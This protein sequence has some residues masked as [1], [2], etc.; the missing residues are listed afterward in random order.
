[1]QPTT[2]SNHG[3]MR[4]V[5]RIS[6]P[7]ILATSGHAL[8]LFADRVMLSQY[9]PEALAAAMPAGLT[10]FCLMAFFI[11]T[12][13]YAGTFVSQYTGAGQPHKTG[14]AIWQ[15]IWISLVGGICVGITAQY[16]EQITSWMQHG[17]AVQAY[18]IPYYD[19]LVRLSFSA[20]LLAALNAFWSGRGHTSVVMGIELFTAVLN[21]L[22]NHVLIFGRY[23]F[24]ELG[25]TGAGLA[26]G[27]S[28]MGGCLIA[29]ILFLSPENRKLFG[30]W[31][32]RL[33]QPN[34][35]TRF[36]RYG[37]PNGT[38][39]SL[40][41]IAF[42]LFVIFL[43][44]FGTAELEAAN[45]AFGLN[46]LAF[47]PLVGLG[48]AVSIL[49]GQCIGAGQI[50]LA[51][52]YVTLSIRLSL[53]YNA[54]IGTLMLTAPNMLIAWFV[55]EGDAAQAEALQLSIVYM[56]FIAAYLLFDGIFIIY[57]H[58]IRGAGDTRFAMI[59]GLL[60]S[61][62]TLSTPAW[63]LQRYSPSAI[64]LWYILVGH[65]MLAGLIFGWRYKQGA[66]IHMRVVETPPAFEIDTHA[67]GGI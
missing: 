55:R 3:G 52:R 44:R 11:G 1:M 31:P 54:V 17:D 2:T 6:I 46:A 40:E 18:Q 63:L 39:F 66:W 50:A 56:R 51:K 23:G 60:L 29:F 36:L 16:A 47:L 45:I 35:L 34:L 25:I 67:E 57:S 15:A 53:G 24:P 27:V 13:G 20:I 26:T 12:A 65:V 41:L 22:L 30:T 5:L 48:M 33:V 59:A 28:S 8:R 42:N 9:A 43:G 62:I 32:C 49:V 21:I 4:R 7:L 64:P 61:W 38:Q 14:S 19:V 37:I 10:A 58:A